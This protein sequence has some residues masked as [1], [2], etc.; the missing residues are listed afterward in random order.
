MSSSKEHRTHE[1]DTIEDEDS[2]EMSLPRADQQV[3]PDYKDQ[4]RPFAHNTAQAAVAADTTGKGRGADVVDKSDATGENQGLRD[5]VEYPDFKDQVQPSL[6]GEER[7]DHDKPEE[8]V[9]PGAFAVYP[10]IRDAQ[11]SDCSSEEEYCADLRGEVEYPDYKD[12]VQPGGHR[13]VGEEQNQGGG[14]AHRAM[15]GEVEYPDCKDQ[16]QAGRHRQVGE[17]QN[18]GNTEADVLPGA[19]AVYPMNL[20]EREAEN[21]ESDAADEED[22]RAHHDSAL[23]QNEFP[24]EEQKVPEDA[25]EDQGLVAAYKVEEGEPVSATFLRSQFSRKRVTL[26]AV[27]VCILIAGIMV[28]GF[29]G[30]GMCGS[31]SPSFS[32]T[33]KLYEAVD[34]YLSTDNPETSIVSQT[35]GYPIGTWDVSK[36]KDFSRVFT[37]NG[38]AHCS[39]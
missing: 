14:G 18:Q 2:T 4:V 33:E 23:D 6:Q 37:Q 21:Q 25:D 27:V 30:S 35:Y 1:D 15:R 13:Q 16:V 9:L 12:Q 11:E 8:N 24:Y 10:T 22:D 34:I 26:I 7:M 20:R 31:D 19:F 32:S 38:T 39:W 17:E 28:A 29:C 3:G 5:E 36:I